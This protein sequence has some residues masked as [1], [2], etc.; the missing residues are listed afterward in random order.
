M[1]FDA[2][3]V[4]L[5]ATVAFNGA[6]EGKGDSS[7]SPAAVEQQRIGFKQFRDFC[8]HALIFSSPTLVAGG[9]GGGGGVDPSS[10]TFAAVLEEAE[11]RQSC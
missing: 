3:A 1:T 5:A 7:S 10:A 2:P 9:G 6:I 4:A 8:V 11:A